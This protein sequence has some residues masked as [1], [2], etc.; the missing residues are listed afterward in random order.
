MTTRA[1]LLDR[2]RD[3]ATWDLVVIGGGATGLGSA[4]DAASRGY[5]TLLLEASDFARGTSSRSTKLIHGGVRYLAQGNL[6]LVR[7]ALHERGVLL[8]NAPHLA[9]RLDFVVPAYSLGGHRLLRARAQ[10]VRPPRRLGRAGRFEA[11]RPVRG[12]PARPD[13]RPGPAPGRDRLRRRP[14]RRRPVRH[15]PGPDPPGPRRGRDQRDAGGRAAQ[16]GR[17]GRGR[18]GP[19]RRDG[20]DASG[21][22]PGPSSTP[23]GSRPTR[24]GRSTTP[25]RRPRWPRAG[26]RTSSSTASFLPGEAAVMIPKTDDG[27]VLFAIPWRGRVLLGTTDTPV[28]RR[29]PASPAPR[30]AEVDYLLDH[31]GRYFAARPGLEDVRST[32]A[33]LRPLIGKGGAGRTVVALARAC[34]VR[35]RLGPGDDH[36]RQVD[37]LPADGRRRRRPGR[38]GRRARRAAPRRPSRSGSTAGPTEPVRRAVRGL[39]VGRPGA[40][41]AGRRAS[42]AGASR[43]TRGWPTAKVEVIWAARFELARTVEDVLA[44]RTRSLFLDARASIEAGARRWP[45]SWPASW[46]SA[47]A[48]KRPRSVAFRTLAAGYLPG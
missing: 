24:S 45:R 32:F 10:G 41:A 40:G 26:A 11:G 23:P 16:G 14:V 6:G 21:S 25:G 22:R 36:R 29:R 9:H 37:D 12:A 35:L 13:A 15:R 7:E 1:D 33:G 28:D 44:R 4:V 27:R 43:S 38:R 48:G 3:G 47:R 8:R 19:R 46:A 39:R 18:R 34:R 42:R 2:L 17:A 30:P 5:S 20:R 31:A